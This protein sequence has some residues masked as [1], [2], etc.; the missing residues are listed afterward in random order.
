L[1]LPLRSVEPYAGLAL[2]YVAADQRRSLNAQ[3]GFSSG[4][5]MLLA[6]GAKAAVGDH[7]IVG[8]RGSARTSAL[9]ETCTLEFGPAVFDM[10]VIFALSSTLDYR[11]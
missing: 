2:G 6:A 10:P 11:W 4:F 5:G 8:L 1:R 7:L 3:C 9:E